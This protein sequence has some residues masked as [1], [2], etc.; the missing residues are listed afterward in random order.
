[1]KKVR[2]AFILATSS[3]I[4]ESYFKPL[5]LGYIKSYLNIHLPE[6]EVTIYENIDQLIQAKPD[7]AGISASTEN[8]AIALDY[9]EEI[10]KHLDCPIIIGGVHVSLLPESLPPGCIGC[11]GEGEETVR[12]LM[13]IFLRYGQF[14]D[15]QLK[16]INGIAFWDAVTKKLMVNPQRE[17]IRPLD[18]L[19]FPDRDALGV[20]GLLF[21]RVET[22]YIFTSRGCP[23][24]CRFCVSRIH[25]N[26]YREFSAA[27]VISEMEHLIRNY[28]VKKIVIF[29]DLFIVNRKRLREIVEEFRARKFD[30]EIFCAVRGNL[31]DDE[32]CQLLRQMNVTEVTFGAESFSEP[33]LQALKCGTVT[34]AQ[35]KNTIELLNKYGISVNCSIIFNSPEQTAEDMIITWKTIFGYLREKKLHRV[36]FGLLRPYPGTY[37]WDLA[38]ERGI[39]SVDMNWTLFKHPETM[40]LNNHVNREALSLLLDEWD[41]KCALVALSYRDGGDKFSSR[42]ELFFKKEFIIKTILDRKDKDDSDL[43]VETEYRNFLSSLKKHDLVLLEGWE[44]PDTN[45]TRWIG[46]KAAFSLGSTI[47]QEGD[48]ISLVFFIPDISYYPDHRITVRLS[49]ETLE[50]ATEVHTNGFHRL[51]VPLKFLPKLLL[52]REVMGTIECS[53]DFI[54]S[55]VSESRDNRRLSVEIIK[56]EIAK[57]TMDNIV[58]FIQLPG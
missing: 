48:Y 11:I 54:P 44:S 32:L 30:V 6:T 15:D 24:D 34:V 23:Y 38:L 45:K 18:S 42:T 47:F 26:K 46:K 16:N 58:N 56:F 22:L 51:S 20:R 25:W 28:H 50:N 41:T 2:L 1:M 49:L 12:E 17:L 21:W 55:R 43:F 53:S 13:E 27:Y 29:D 5:G 9:V 33:V 19:P 4:A 36:G 57:K 52:K 3:D 37:Y 31:V 35:N 7:C 14:T 40:N 10:K 8:Y 39:V